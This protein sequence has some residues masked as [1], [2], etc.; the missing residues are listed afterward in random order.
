MGTVRLDGADGHDRHRLRPVEV[1]NLLPGQVREVEDCHR[2]AVSYRARRLTASRP[3]PISVTMSFQPPEQFNIADYFLDARI[4]EGKGE[5]PAVLTDAGTLTYREIQALANRFG[6]V[7][8][9]SGVEP[10]QRVM[11]ALPDGPGFVGALFGTL[12]IGAAVVMANPQLKP[13]AIAYFYDYTRARVVVAHRDTVD[14]FRSAARGARHL[15]TILVIG[16]D[17]FDERL[18]RAPAALDLFP[19]HRD[20]AA[21]WLFSG[22][23]TGQP[24]PAV[25]THTSFA[26][27]TECY[28]KG[29]IGY[30]ERDVTLSVPK[31][32]FGYATGSNLLFPFSVGAAT[33]L[34]PEATTA[35]V[36]FQKIAR[37]RPTI[38][39]N[40]PTM[41]N[42]MVSHP[43][44]SKQD[45]SCLRLATSA[46]EA[47]P[48][49]LY[50]RWKRTFGVE[51]L[52]GLGTA[53]M[54]HIFISNRPGH[55][56][57]GTLGTVVPGFEVKVCDDAGRELPNGEVGALW[58]RGGSRAIGYWQQMEKTK[59]GF[60]GE[61]YVSGDMVRRD[62]DGY[63]T[64]CG[65]ADDLLKVSGKWLAPQEVENCLLQHPA[66]QEVAVELFSFFQEVFQQVAETFGQLAP[67]GNGVHVGVTGFLGGQGVHESLLARVA[68]ADSK[69]TLSL[70][71]GF[72]GV[73]PIAKPARSLYLLR[74]CASTR[75][76]V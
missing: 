50:D 54:W 41:I 2:V 64:Y 43:A 73:R 62:A 70:R 57:P 66:V 65:R 31:L 30:S 32:Y 69:Y 36:L 48:A 71:R 13:D 55:V 44:A 27:T 7:F 21:L 8:T 63:F 11:I 47:L 37:F 20:D 5:R 72:V 74:V 45:L 59:Q 19:T 18:A 14:A 16:D 38:L 12:K 56:R 26:N 1:A 28:A 3:R 9:E 33:A 49:E 39:I 58:V 29:T 17:E 15:K 60:L 22:G 61:W 51:L 52:D 46:G 4:R 68:L 75:L 53:E 35:E 24:K 67:R 10:E 42:Q 23:T 6:H 34:F 40:V 76:C 25:Q